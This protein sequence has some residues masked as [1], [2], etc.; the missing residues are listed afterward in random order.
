M[1]CGASRGV[2]RVGCR[3]AVCLSR[4]LR[5]QRTR[6]AA[7]VEWSDAETGALRSIVID[8]GMDLRRQALRFGVERLDGALVTHIHVDHTGGIDELR[9]YTDAQDEVLLLGAGPGTA[10]ELRQRWEYAVDGRTAPGH[11]IPAL[12]V[13]V[14]DPT[15]HIAGRTFEAVPIVHGRR[16]AHGWRSGGFAYLTDVASVAASSRSRLLGLDLLV[17]SALR[18]LPHPTHQTVEEALE[19]IAALAPARAVLTHLDHDLDYEEL[20]G[21]LPANVFAAFDGLVVTVPSR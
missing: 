15:V 12:R 6:S 7:L 16:E 9:A 14:A 8:P 11:G 18:D 17:V 20:A 21:R 4:D 5:N 13:A 2:P 3:C 10:A 1:G 19:L